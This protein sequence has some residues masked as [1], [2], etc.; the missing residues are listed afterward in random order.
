[1]SIE[2][3]ITQ[4]TVS[5]SSSVQTN[6]LSATAKTGA[7]P[8]DILLAQINPSDDNFFSQHTGKTILNADTN[9]DTQA[10]DLP[11]IIALN[12]RQNIYSL[13]RFLFGLDWRGTAPHQVW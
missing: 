10:Q 4:Q 11:Q 2:T 12:Q 1:M 9:I 3:L 7:S 8:F 13:R 5:N 6:A